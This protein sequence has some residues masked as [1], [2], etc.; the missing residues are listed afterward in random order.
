MQSEASSTNSDQCAVEIEMSLKGKARK[1]EDEL[2]I[3]DEQYAELV[4]LLGCPNLKK[5]TQKAL[6]DNKPHR[7]SVKLAIENS[8]EFIER[9]ELSLQ[10]IETGI[11][12]VKTEM[13]ELRKIIERQD[14]NSEND[15]LFSIPGSSSC[16]NWNPCPAFHIWVVLGLLGALLVIDLATLVILILRK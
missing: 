2:Q 12:N 8:Q 6:E 1:L 5:Q 15:A 16:W 10:Q 13:A 14:L 11:D 4:Q 9:T 7:K 3:A